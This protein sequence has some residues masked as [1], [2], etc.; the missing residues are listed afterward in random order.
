MPKNQSDRITLKQAAK[1]AVGY[2]Y[3]LY[4]Q[5]NTPSANVMLEEVEEIDDGMNWLITIGYNANGKSSLQQ[6]LHAF[7]FGPPNPRQ[8]KVIKIDAKTGRVI[9]MK[10]RSVK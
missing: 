1:I 9:S 2:F 4:P 8:Y 3:G 10:I 7:S 6:Q 5:F